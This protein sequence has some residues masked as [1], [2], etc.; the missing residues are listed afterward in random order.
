[1][2]RGSPVPLSL[3]LSLGQWDSSFSGQFRPRLIRRRYGVD[4]VEATRLDHYWL[5]RGG[6][7]GRDHPF[8][9]ETGRRELHGH[10][11]GPQAVPPLLAR[12]VIAEEGLLPRHWCSKAFIGGALIATAAILLP[13]M[14]HAQQDSPEAP[15]PGMSWGSPPTEAEWEPTT[16][17]GANEGS[18]QD[19]SAAQEQHDEATERHQEQVLLSQQAMAEQAKR[20]ADFMFWQLLVGVVV[21]IGLGITIYYAH[22]I[23]RAVHNGREASTIDRARGLAQPVQPQRA[24]GNQQRRAQQ[25]DAPNS[26]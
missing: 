24:D 7:R 21:L 23:A 4:R 25:A 15:L 1:M 2:P 5:G 6:L 3:S 18:P 16:Q 8:E 22:Q 20:M 11:V 14:L 10:R 19:Q 26:S 9:L 13:T 12:E 17:G